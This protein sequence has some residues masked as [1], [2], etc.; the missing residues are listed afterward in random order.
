MKKTF[1]LFLMSCFALGMYAQAGQDTVAYYAFPETSYLPGTSGKNIAGV[2]C[3]VTYSGIGNKESNAA[4]V[5][6][7]YYLKFTGD[8]SYVTLQPTD[9]SIAPGDSVFVTLG[10]TGKREL[11]VYLKTQ[12]SGTWISATQTTNGEVV[13]AKAKLTRDDIN[14]DGSISFFRKDGNSTFVRSFLVTHDPNAAAATEYYVTYY[15]QL[16]NKLG[17]VATPVSNPTLSIAYGEEDLP[18]ISEGEVFRGWKTAIGRRVSEGEL[19]EGDLTVYACVTDEEVATP[20]ARFLYNMSTPYFYADEH[21]CFSATA[22]GYAPI[23]NGWYFPGGGDIVL[24]VSPN[25]YIEV[26]TGGGITTN[27][28]ADQQ[29]VTLSFNGGDFV[30]E[31]NIYNVTEEVQKEHGYYIVPAD[32]A[33]YLLMALRQLQDRDKVFLPNGIYDLGNLCLTAINK[34]NVSLIGESMEGVIIRNT[35]LAPGISS[36]ATLQILGD[37]V[38]LQD[39]TLQNNF[40]YYA[41]NE[42]QADAL[43]VKGTKAICKNVRLLSYQDTYYSNYIGGLHYFEDCEIHGTVDFICGDGSVFFENTLLY[44]EKR[45]ANGGGSDALTASNADASDKGYVFHNCR[46]QSECPTI[47]LGRSWKN[48][49]QCYFLNTTLDYSQGNFTLESGDIQRWTTKG[50]NALPERFG[51]YK[52][53]DV[54]GNI[55]SPATNEVTFT[56]NGETKSMETI[57]TDDEA[58]A[59]SYENFFGDIWDPADEAKQVNALPVEEDGIYLVENPDGHCFITT[60][61]ELNR[62]DLVPDAT[63]RRA[64]ARGGFGYKAGQEPKSEGIENTAADKGKIEKVVRN[65]QLLILRGNA[66]YTATGRQIAR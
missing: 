2:N 52:T 48:A 21:E 7:I 45:Q 15:D 51:E 56:L 38:Y 47:S 18:E 49:P 34:N 65:G 4:I 14:D 40:D 43:H 64:N 23:E 62:A 24:T 6:G 44:A 41:K 61:E 5:D 12:G 11:G 25:V 31:L 22:G 58:A 19:L 35:A 17:E 1:F 60:G 42:G 20:T 29:T 3:T 37:N 54:D 57:L 66:L 8:A 16:G 30:K 63:I 28:Y 13:V 36:T 26:V 33:N 50:M 9:G 46:V 53:M 59:L 39:L 10:H 32:D 55:I 27:F